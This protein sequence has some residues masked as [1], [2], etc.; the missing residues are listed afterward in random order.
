MHEALPP[1]PVSPPLDEDVPPA[2]LLDEDAPPAPPA[3]LDAAADD[4]DDDAFALEDAADEDA[5]PLPKSP[6]VPPLLHA[7]GRSRT[8]VRARGARIVR[9]SARPR[10]GASWKGRRGPI[11]RAA[12]RRRVK[13]MKAQRPQWIPIAEWDAPYSGEARELERV[14]GVIEACRRGDGVV[15]TP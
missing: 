1:E 7:T 15:S 11:V 13:R 9:S 14:R 8:R 2:P 3:L 10:A 12:P 4:D 6:P 5:P